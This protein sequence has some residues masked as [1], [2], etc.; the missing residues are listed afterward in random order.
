MAT[1]ESIA[2]GFAQDRMDLIVRQL[3]Q[4]TGESRRSSARI[5]AKFIRRNIR[6]CREQLKALDALVRLIE[7]EN[8]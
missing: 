8:S 1:L 7:E 6:E 3:S 2:L 4:L 5:R